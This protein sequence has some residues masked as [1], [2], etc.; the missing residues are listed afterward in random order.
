MSFSILMSGVNISK[1]F[2]LFKHFGLCSITSRAYCIHQNKL[3]VPSV[4][5]VALGEVSEFLDRKSKKD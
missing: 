4:Y 1:V 2:L 5:N 3:L